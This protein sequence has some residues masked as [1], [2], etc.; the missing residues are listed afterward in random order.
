[1]KKLV[2]AIDGPA[3]SGKSTIAKE[4][5]K[6]YNILHLN[7]GSMYRAFALFCINNNVDFNNEQN[8]DKIIDM[9]DLQIKFQNGEQIDLLQGEVVTHLLRSENVS[10]ASS[11][12]S[13]FAK[14]RHKAV[15]IQRKV[16]SE[17]NVVMEGRD[18]TS[19]VLP[20]ADFKFFITA[21]VEERA[22]RRYKELIEKGVDCDYDTIYNDVKQRDERDIGRKV[23]PLVVVSDAVVVDT[24][25]LSIEQVVEEFA[26][27]I[28]K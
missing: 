19:V 16:A 3:G 7:T 26:K 9:I 24:T 11:I 28:E 1:M 5:A 17:I 20:D 10:K 14:V 25:N 13:Q 2:I 27:V 21:T 15:Q 23:S 6:R 22:K 8:V 4:L 18:I 12:I